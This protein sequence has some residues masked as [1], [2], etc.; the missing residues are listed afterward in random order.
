MIL[1]SEKQTD[2]SGTDKAINDTL[3]NVYWKLSLHY[4]RQRTFKFQLNTLLDDLSNNFRANE[5]TVTIA[6]QKI[7]FLIGIA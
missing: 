3:V 2:Q 4:Y 6:P 7:T 5:C 1:Q